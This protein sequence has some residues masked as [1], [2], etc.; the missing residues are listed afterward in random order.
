MTKVK[1]LFAFLV[2]SCTICLGNDN[3]TESILFERYK[4]G[5]CGYMDSEGY[6]MGARCI[7]PSPDG[8]CQRISDCNILVDH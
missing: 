3:Q 4:T 1:I 8:P 2:I 6:H 7:E 5:V